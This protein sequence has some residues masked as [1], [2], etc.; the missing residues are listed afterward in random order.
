MTLVVLHFY[1]SL[2]ISHLLMSF[3]FCHFFIETSLNT[4]KVHFNTILKL[5]WINRM[6]QKWMKTFLISF[7]FCLIFFGTFCIRNELKISFFTWFRSKSPFFFLVLKQSLCNLTEDYCVWLLYWI[8]RLSQP[9]V[10]CI[11][12][13]EYYWIIGIFL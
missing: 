13:D 11:I 8:I 9:L 3:I 2:N 10:L 5:I 4:I 1:R 12:Y 6:S 7:E